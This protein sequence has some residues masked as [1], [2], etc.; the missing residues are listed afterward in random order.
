MDSRANSNQESIVIRHIKCYFSC[1]ICLQYNNIYLS[2]PL[3]LCLYVV[4][5]ILFILIRKCY[6]WTVAHITVHRLSLIVYIG[7]YIGKFTLT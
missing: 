1:K 7:A 5:I 4:S 3:P 2:T 6:Y